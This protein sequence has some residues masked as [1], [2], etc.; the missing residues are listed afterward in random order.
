[1]TLLKAQ[2]TDADFL[3]GILRENTDGNYEINFKVKV[4]DSA[5]TLNDILVPI[6]FS[7]KLDL[8]LV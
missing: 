8:N 2:F 1:M 4:K 5:A 7:Q 6:P 3:D